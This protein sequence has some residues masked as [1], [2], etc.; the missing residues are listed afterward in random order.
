MLN[1]YGWL[2]DLGLMDTARIVFFSGVFTVYQRETTTR[3]S[4]H[5]K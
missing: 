4:N 1:Y 2:V 3:Y 5:D